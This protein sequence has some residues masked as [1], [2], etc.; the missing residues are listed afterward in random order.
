MKRTQCTPKVHIRQL[1]HSD[2][3]DINHHFSRL[4]P[5]SRRA[6]FCG[7]MS[8][9]MIRG[10]AHEIFNRAGFVGGAFVDGAIRGLV[11]LHTIHNRGG[12]IAEVALSVECDWQNLGI[13]DALFDHVLAIARNWG[14]VEIQT[15]CM[16]DNDR[17]R[18]LA[19]KH[20]ATL[21][22]GERTVSAVLRADAPS[23]TCAVQD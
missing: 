7:G 10:Y 8:D 6:R 12:K 3:A 19:E 16:R 11:E 15:I 13:G 20:D 21:T 22:F 4:D 2:R 14:F 9:R 5:A 23:L 18:H 17:M 1:R